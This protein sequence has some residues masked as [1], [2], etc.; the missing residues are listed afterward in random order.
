VPRNSQTD[1]LKHVLIL[2]RATPNG[3][4]TRNRN[5]G[6]AEKQAIINNNNN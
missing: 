5:T 6:A 1:F 3:A 4:I 2:N